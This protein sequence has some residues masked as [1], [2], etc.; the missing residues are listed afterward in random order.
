MSRLWTAE[1]RV[2]LSP[3]GAVLARTPRGFAK[4]PAYE[5]LPG[6]DLAAVLAAQPKVRADLHV[7]LSNHHVRF[8]V[9]PW[10]AALKNDA[11]W[12][13]FATHAFE[14]THGRAARDWSIACSSAERGAPRLACAV[15]RTRIAAIREA[16]ERTPHV[17]LRSIRPYLAVAF[18]RMRAAID[19]APAWLAVV[20]EGRIVLALVAKGHWIA[21][22]ARGGRGDAAGRL[23]RAIAMESSLLEPAARGTRLVVVDGATDALDLARIGLP[24]VDRTLPAGAAPAHRPYSL[25]LAG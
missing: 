3:E 20:E 15:D 17:R 18:E 8:A 5:R 22:R 4:R 16:C 19:D 13:A 1:L 14:A 11:E 6:A 23:A 2:G 7:V 25:A 10:S 12:T 9:L 21:V 24:V